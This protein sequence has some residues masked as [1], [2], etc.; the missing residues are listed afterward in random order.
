MFLRLVYH[1]RSR[2]GLPRDQVSKGS[3]EESVNQGVLENLTTIQEESLSDTLSEQTYIISMANKI[4]EMS[5]HS[6]EADV[7]TSARSGK[8]VSVLLQ[9][10][11]TNEKGARIYL[12]P[13]NRSYVCEELGHS[14][15]QEQVEP[16]MNRDRY[17]DS[18][19]IAYLRMEYPNLVDP[20]GML[21]MKEKTSEVSE[22][23]PLEN[24][25]RARFV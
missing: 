9:Y 13:Q 6:C 24:D 16:I 21:G 25:L 20:M 23:P 14:D 8:Q 12:D 7:G 2:E 18:N 4:P 22:R 19:A 17:I 11:Y 15:I 10:Y 1:Y 3:T 5:F